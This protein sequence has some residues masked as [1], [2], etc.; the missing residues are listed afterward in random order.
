MKAGPKFSSAA[1]HKGDHG[2][3]AEV[4]NRVKRRTEVAT[5]HDREG[6]E[7]EKQGSGTYAVTWYQRNKLRSREEQ[8]WSQ[9]RERVDLFLQEGINVNETTSKVNI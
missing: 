1:K 5:W 7:A 2:I 4:K 6:T 9:T 8:D 3:V